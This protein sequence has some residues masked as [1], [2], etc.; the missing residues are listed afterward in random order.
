MKE[1]YTSFSTTSLSEIHEQ[2]DFARQKIAQQEEDNR[3]RDELDARRDEE[4]RRAEAKISEMQ[5]FIEYMKNTD[6]RFVAYMSQ[7]NVVENS[8]ANTQPIPGTAPLTATATAQ[9]SGPVIAPPTQ[10]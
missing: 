5:K 2:L 3:R 9:P 4:Q 8:P 10:P 1:S 7:P 6:P